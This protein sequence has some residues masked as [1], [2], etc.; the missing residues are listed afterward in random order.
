MIEI[1]IKVTTNSPMNIGAGAQTGTL[2]DRGMI[3][4]A[5]G[6]PYV[7]ATTLKGKMRHAVEQIA[8][9][10]PGGTPV[11][12]T[13][14]DM[15][16]TAPCRVCQLF[17]SPWIPGCVQFNKLTLTGPPAI[18]GMRDELKRKRKQ[19]RSTLRT[20]VTI[21]RRRQVA[22]DQRLYS[23]ELILPGIPL[24]LSGSVRGR[25]TPAQA[26]LLV[27]GLHH[28]PAIGQGKSGGLGWITA[29]TTVMNN[30]VEVSNDALLAALKQSVEVGT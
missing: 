4:D 27:A 11:C 19:I 8:H 30:S 1:A 2:A 17:G 24:E 28:I 16:R 10:L 29:E 12:E 25:I 20:G 7:P 26:G 14:R 18:I 15:C 9:T 13:H 3:K 23:T 22:Q 5:D 6:L 21:N